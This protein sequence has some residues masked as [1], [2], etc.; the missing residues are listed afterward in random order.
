M[1]PR[2]RSGHFSTGERRWTI[3]LV[4]FGENRERF[5][6]KETQHLW[7]V[8]MKR[9]IS[10]L[11]LAVV[12]ALSLPS[13]SAQQETKQAVGRKV[14][15]RVAPS[16]PDIARRMNLTGTVKVGVVVA[17]NG[18]VKQTHVIGGNP[19]LVDAALA[20]VQKW[21]FAAGPEET[22]ELV[23]LKFVSPR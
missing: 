2:C 18:R 5:I 17:P 19:V 8:F 9:S 14:T 22:T 13:A 23:E 15:S 11:V 21:R 4:T 20:A 7:L 1:A 16:Y 12:L 6:L 3:T 10:P